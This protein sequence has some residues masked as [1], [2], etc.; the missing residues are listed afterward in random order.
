MREQFSHDWSQCSL[1]LEALVQVDRWLHI[2]YLHN[3]TSK[4]K[5]S[6][7]KRSHESAAQSCRPDSTFRVQVPG[8]ELQFA[9]PVAFKLSQLGHSCGHCKSIIHGRASHGNL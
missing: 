2:S 4:T 3:F 9:L 6:C 8:S 1:A 5:V 7:N